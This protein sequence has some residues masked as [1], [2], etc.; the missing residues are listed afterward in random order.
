M[1][2][3]RWGCAKEQRTLCLG[4]TGWVQNSFIWQQLWT[5][6]QKKEGSRRWRCLRGHLDQLVRQHIRPH[7]WFMV[8]FKLA[9]CSQFQSVPTSRHMSL[10]STIHKFEFEWSCPTLWLSSVGQTKVGR[11]GWGC[12]CPRNHARLI[13]TVLHHEMT[14]GKWPPTS[15]SLQFPRFKRKVWVNG[16]KMITSRVLI[17]ITPLSRDIIEGL[18]QKNF[19]I[20]ISTY[21]IQKLLGFLEFLVRSPTI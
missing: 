7:L 17:P 11:V 13:T 4:E 10:A 18:W 3:Q 14:L 1:E 12:A 2:I 9:A 16:V 6:W 21:A 15:C 20:Q 8:V 19:F 5:E